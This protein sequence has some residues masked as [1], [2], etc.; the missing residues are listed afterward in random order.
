MVAITGKYRWQ[1]PTG[2]RGSQDGGQALNIGLAAAAT[3]KTGD[4]G[5]NEQASVDAR[6]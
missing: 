1:L 5:V 2:R 4:G 6:I 3:G